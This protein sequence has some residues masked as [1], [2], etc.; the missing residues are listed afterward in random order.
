MEKNAVFCCRKAVAFF[1]TTFSARYSTRTVKNK[2][3]K[4]KTSTKIFNNISSLGDCWFLAALSLLDSATI[5][6]LF[7]TRQYS[8]MGVYCM[9][10]YSGGVWKRVV[11]DDFIPS[12]PLTGFL[13]FDLQSLETMRTYKRGTGTHATPGPIYGRV[14]EMRCFWLPLLEKGYAK[15]NRTYEAISGG[16]L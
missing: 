5:F 2:K 1:W 14:P 12:T 13:P 15:L 11:V 8:P 7:E 16:T 3:K 9:R 10:F 4:K 6:K